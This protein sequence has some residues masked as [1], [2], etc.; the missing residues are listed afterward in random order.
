MA[1]AYRLEKIPNLK[2]E[3]ETRKRIYALVVNGKC[4]VINYLE[5]VISDNELRSVMVTLK[6]LGEQDVVRNTKKVIKIKSHDIWELRVP[7]GETRISFF[8][9][10]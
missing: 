5:N 2:A 7:K 1:T 8:F 3:W 10:W 9:L 6:L 4:A